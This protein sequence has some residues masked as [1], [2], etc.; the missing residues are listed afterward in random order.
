MVESKHAGLGWRCLVAIWGALI[1]AIGIGSWHI[2]SPKLPSGEIEVDAFSA[3]RAMKHVRVIAREPHPTGT[4][5]NDTVR[6][7]LIGQL[8][9]L[10]LQL[11]F[12]P[13]SAWRQNSGRRGSPI[14][15]SSVCPDESAVR[16]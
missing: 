4:A 12:S 5:S 7:Y 6:S 3:A 16:P 8:Q 15:S 1:A 10:G 9:A 14:T 2:A 11:K 13:V